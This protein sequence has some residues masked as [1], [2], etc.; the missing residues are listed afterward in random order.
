M[1]AQLAA[2]ESREDQRSALQGLKKLI[3]VAA[4][5]QPLTVHYDS[6]Q[7]HELH[8]F[9]YKGKV[10]VIWRIRNGNVRLPFYYGHRKLIFLAGVMS[11]RKDSLSKAEK[12]ALER[13]VKHY[14][15]AEAESELL[16]EP[17]IPQDAPSSRR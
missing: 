11:K 8:E 5:G 3:Q 12:L 1:F 9:T 10:R 13:Q 14:I 15:D 6:K 17:A 4:I 2:L 16:L 7:C